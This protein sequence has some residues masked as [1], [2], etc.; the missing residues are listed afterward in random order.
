MDFTSSLALSR[1][2]LSGWWSRKG[3]AWP[4]W[5]CCGLSRPCSGRCLRPNG[6]PAGQQA[7]PRPHRM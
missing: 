7:Q 6:L 4:M 5:A 3:T 1:G 2:G